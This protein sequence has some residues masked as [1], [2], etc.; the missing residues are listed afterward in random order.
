MSLT[1]L[2]KKCLGRGQSTKLPPPGVWGN[3]GY[4][5]ILVFLLH[6]PFPLIFFLHS[7][8]H[9]VPHPLHFLQ[10]TS[11]PPWLMSLS[12]QGVWRIRKPLSPSWVLMLRMRPGCRSQG[13]KRR[14][15]MFSLGDHEMGMLHTQSSSQDMC[16][17]CTLRASGISGELRCQTLNTATVHMCKSCFQDLRLN[18]S[19]YSV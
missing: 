15:A 4:V 12:R 9:R 13:Q 17:L 2:H 10:V 1:Q 5:I 19:S 3:S 14:K 8:Q 6:P 16:N 7:P 11:S 18:L